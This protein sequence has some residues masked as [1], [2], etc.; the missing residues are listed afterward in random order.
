LADK[1]ETAMILKPLTF[2]LL[3]TGVAIAWPR[4]GAPSENVLPPE[5]GESSRPTDASTPATEQGQG[6]HR[7]DLVHPAVQPA[8]DAS[9]EDLLTPPLAETHS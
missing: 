2:L 7:L 8:D 5:A 6:L 3:V 9:H 4:R 1:P